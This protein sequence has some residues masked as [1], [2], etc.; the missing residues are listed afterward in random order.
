MGFGPA[1]AGAV[2]QGVGAIAQAMAIAVAAYFA[3]NTFDGW[4]KQK[5]SERRFEQAERILTAAYRARRALRFVRSPLM[6]D[7]ELEVARV[8][9]ENEE[10]WVNVLP[11]NRNGFVESRAYFNRLEKVVD[12]QRAI[13]VCLP[14]A[15]ALFGEKVEVALELLNM[16]FANVRISAESLIYDRGEIPQ[17]SEMLSSDINHSLLDQEYN[18]VDFIIAAQIKLIEDTL[19]PVLRVSL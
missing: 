4:R 3:S 16:Q 7:H 12:E 8:Q 18:Q 13:E 9:S 15:R 19:V 2:L 10:Y 5:I 14:M 6:L 17:Y 1:D 11:E